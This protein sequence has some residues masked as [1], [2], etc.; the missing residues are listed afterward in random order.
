MIKWNRKMNYVISLLTERA[1][2]KDARF[3][4]Y[5]DD[6]FKKHDE[7]WS[8]WFEEKRKISYKKALLNSYAAPLITAKVCKLLLE[9]TFKNVIEV[10]RELS[11]FNN[12]IVRVPDFIQNPVYMNEMLDD[13]IPDKYDTV[14]FVEKEKEFDFNELVNYTSHKKKNLV[15]L[16]DRDYVYKDFSS[17]Y[18]VN[19]QKAV[20]SLL[21]QLVSLKILMCLL[22]LLPLITG[23]IE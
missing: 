14:I 3:Y 12:N 1:Y 22:F 9:K 7:I 19:I 18:F 20:K 2:A 8:E 13:V 23:I 4:N 15:F 5:S 21:T 6:V 10:K 16:T 11:R 17:D